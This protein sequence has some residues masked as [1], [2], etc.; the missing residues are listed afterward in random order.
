VRARLLAATVAPVLLAG[1]GL[2]AVDLEAKGHAIVPG[3]GS[4]ASGPY[5][6]MSFPVM[7]LDLR[8]TSG[9]SA[10]EIE[11]AQLRSV[12][13]TVTAGSPLETWVDSIALWVEAGG[14]ERVLVA[15]RD[16]VGALPAGQT[17]LV[18]DVVP[19]VEL[20]P[21]IAASA[22][23]LVADGSARQPSALT[24]VDVAAVVRVRLDLAS[25]F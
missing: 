1:C 22:A 5:A 18:L 14:L 19:G 15:R 3:S 11:S 6:P 25:I 10:R 16:G 17:T 21:W 20:Q 23:V 9:F 24:A 7:S 13:V 12:T 4:T 2:D 8:R